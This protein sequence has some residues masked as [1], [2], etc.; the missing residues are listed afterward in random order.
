MGEWINVLQRRL[1]RL[2]QSV[3]SLQD[4]A[5]NQAAQTTALGA[6]VRKHEA[7]FV[8]EDKL[9]ALF[10]LVLELAEVVNGGVGGIPGAG[11]DRR[12]QDKLARVPG[13][14]AAGSTRA[15]AGVGFAGFSMGFHSLTRGCP[16]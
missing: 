2:S 5:L 10:K 16:S 7:T 15:A 3:T 11:I 4:K 6:Q 13:S 8:E 9:P 14:Q 1:S 12:I